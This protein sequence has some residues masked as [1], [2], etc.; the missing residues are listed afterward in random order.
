MSYNG[1]FPFVLAHGIARP[2]YLIDSLFRTLNLSLYDF[3]F[4]SDRFA[5]FKG[6]ASHL[7]K[8]EVEVFH[9]RVSFAAGVGVRSKDLKKEIQ[10]ILQKT[11]SKKVHII[12]HSMG[13]LD[14]RH[15]IVKENMADKVASLTTIGTPHMGTSAA[16]T[17][18]A[19]GADNIIARF[20]YILNLEGVKS[21]TIK[22]CNAFNERARDKE[23][24]ND[25]YYQTYSSYQEEKSVFLPFQV[26]WK[27][28]RNNEGDNDDNQ[29]EMGQNT[30]C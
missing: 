30:I 11:K 22:A 16:D 4:V 21:V 20:K 29:D 17:A 13:G 12:A 2:D 3:S 27:T 19:Q 23:A 1:T 5:Y 10:K 15:M 9:S 25:V 28:I 26:S 7:K 14:A 6:I 24:T 8:H 18:L